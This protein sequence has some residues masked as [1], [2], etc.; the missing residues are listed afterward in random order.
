MW[1]T[2][3]L[4]WKLFNKE[5][6]KSSPLTNKHVRVEYMFAECGFFNEMIK[7]LDKS[8][9]ENLDLHTDFAH[10]HRQKRYVVQSHIE[11]NFHNPTHHSFKTFD[12]QI[13]DFDKVDSVFPVRPEKNVS[14]IVITHPGH[15]RFE[16][17][18]FLKKNRYNI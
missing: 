3:S 16:A 2:D 18:C 1:R 7:E 14:L 11:D 12:K 4:P 15:T 5:N 6:G 17:S 10:F 13:I 9:L 8:Y